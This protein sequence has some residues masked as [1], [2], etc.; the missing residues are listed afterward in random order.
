MEK[1]GAVKKKTEKSRKRLRFPV[2]LFRSDAIFFILLKSVV[3]NSIGNTIEP[4]L[5][6]TKVYKFEMKDEY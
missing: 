2:P 3:D 5:F 4:Y 6:P 1:K